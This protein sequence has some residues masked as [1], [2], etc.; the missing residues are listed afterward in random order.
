MVGAVFLRLRELLYLLYL[1]SSCCGIDGGV[2]I[3]A[4]ETLVLAAG[5][6]VPY[7]VPVQDVGQLLSFWSASLAPEVFVVAIATAVLLSSTYVQVFLGQSLDALL[8]PL[9]F[10]DIRFWRE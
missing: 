4:G 7:L 3:V 1:W 6:V 2:L 5:R 9:P 10:F 8:R